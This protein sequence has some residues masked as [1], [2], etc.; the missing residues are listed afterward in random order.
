[1]SGLCDGAQHAWNMS[2][3]S[4]FGVLTGTR[5]IDDW[6][7]SALHGADALRMR[8]QQR[9]V[10]RLACWRCLD[11]CSQ[12]VFPLQ[13]PQ[14]HH[15]CTAKEREFDIRSFFRKCN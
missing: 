5:T 9:V 12:V 8:Q 3:Q 13:K 7:F 6:I 10:P 1:V 15:V 2:R 4:L 14:H 11:M